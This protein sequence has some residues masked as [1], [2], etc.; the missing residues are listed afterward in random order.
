MYEKEPYKTAQ[1]LVERLE[2][3][4]PKR[5]FD[6]RWKFLLTYENHLELEN[7]LEVL[8]TNCFLFNLE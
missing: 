7:V 3:L 1:D 8:E 6:E 2:D 5:P 4:S